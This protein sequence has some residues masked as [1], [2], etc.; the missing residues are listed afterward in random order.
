MR[1]HCL[2]F[3]CVKP[4]ESSTQLYMVVMQLK[5]IQNPQH[6]LYIE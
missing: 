2:K 4:S 3:R 5:Q 6:F 1:I